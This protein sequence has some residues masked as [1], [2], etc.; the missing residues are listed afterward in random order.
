MSPCSG[1]WRTSQPGAVAMRETERERE[2]ERE[3]ER[4]REI[5]I[6]KQA[7]VLALSDLISVK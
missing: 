3:S 5:Q 1:A 6:V 4:E 7:H 2:R